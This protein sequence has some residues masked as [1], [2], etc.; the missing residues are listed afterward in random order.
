ME[1]AFVSKCFKF[2]LSISAM[3][4]VSLISAIFYL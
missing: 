3:F 2:R 1:I 4:I